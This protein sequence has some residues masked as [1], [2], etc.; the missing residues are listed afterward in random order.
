MITCTLLRLDDQLRT[1]VAPSIAVSEADATDLLSIFQF[2]LCAGST[3]LPI[4]EVQALFDV[5]K[6][7]RAGSPALHAFA[8]QHVDAG[9][10]HMVIEA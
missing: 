5:Q 4:N 10:S 2:K 3:L 6:I 1:S 7:C 8:A 9:A